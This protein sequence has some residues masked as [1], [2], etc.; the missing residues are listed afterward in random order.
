MCL[1]WLSHLITQTDLGL[2]IPSLK[3]QYSIVI[4][5][6]IPAFFAYV[7]HGPV[8]HTPESALYIPFFSRLSIL[9]VHQTTKLQPNRR[10]FP[11]HGGADWSNLFHIDDNA[12]PSRHPRSSAHSY[13]ATHR[14]VFRPRSFSL[15]KLGPRVL[16]CLGFGFDF[17]S[18]KMVILVRRVPG[19]RIV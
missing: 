11:F 13:P 8:P 12:F 19:Y 16:L 10:S 4:H 15:P 3:N 2:T 6:M 1:G 14:D 17:D 9:S 7:A 18:M 5:P